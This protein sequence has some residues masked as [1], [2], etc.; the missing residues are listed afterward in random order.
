MSSEGKGKGT[1]TDSNIHNNNNKKSRFNFIYR[2]YHIVVHVHSF[3]V[4]LSSDLR[5][6]TDGMKYF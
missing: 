3:F 2:R 6:Y 1:L 5:N 4:L